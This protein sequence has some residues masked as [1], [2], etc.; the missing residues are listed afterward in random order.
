MSGDAN[1]AKLPPERA[2]RVWIFQANPKRYRILDSLRTETEELWN[3][4]Q[5]VEEIAPGDRVLIWLCGDDAG[6]Y[7]LGTVTT[8]AVIRPD[9]PEGQ[10]YWNDKPAGK[11]PIARAKV[12]YDRKLLERPVLKAFL[13]NDPDL[14]NLSVMRQPR[15]TN[16]PVRENEWGSLQDWFVDAAEPSVSD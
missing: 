13:V 10:A 1:Q 6:I 9:T 4:R 11:R 7:A 5:H 8:A 2:A 14:W 15:G 3:I 16:F 12:R